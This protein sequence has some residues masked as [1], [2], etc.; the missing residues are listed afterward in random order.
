MARVKRTEPG[1]RCECL[2]WI[3][4]ASWSGAGGVPFARERSA[5]EMTGTRRLGVWAVVAV[6]MALV[7]ALLVPGTATSSTAAATIQL[8][9]AVGP[10]TSI[11]KASGSRF[12]ADEKVDITF[13]QTEVTLARTDGTGAFRIRF[14]VPGSARPGGHV[15]RATGRMT[16]RSAGEIFE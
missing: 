16:R 11:V 7:G 2:R 14:Q 3:L 4:E 6:S 8:K 13:D 10:P 1:G 12:G 9:P 5:A 15:V